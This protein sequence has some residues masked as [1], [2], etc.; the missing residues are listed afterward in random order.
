MTVLA[1]QAPK[2]PVVVQRERRCIRCSCRLSR[3]NSA[4]LCSGCSREVT[5]AE[6]MT[7]FVPPHVWRDDDVSEALIQ[8][9]FGTLCRL[10]RERGELRQEDLAVLTDL[11][12]S[13]LSQL[14][15]GRRR[16]T[17]I[18]RIISLLDGLGAPVEVTGP[19][20]RP[21]V[22]EAPHGCTTELSG[23]AV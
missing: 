4:D 5:L 12:Q 6:P 10:I 13:F 14:E 17:N 9:D 3:Y 11:S 1:M 16:L 19:M 2:A 15:A 23:I 18:D 7:P 22:G 21:H 8:R 20:L